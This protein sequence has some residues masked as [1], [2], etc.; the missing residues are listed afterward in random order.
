MA[1]CGTTDIRNLVR[2]NFTAHTRRQTIRFSTALM[3]PVILPIQAFID[4]GLELLLPDT[5][6]VQLC[7]KAD[8]RL[9][10]DSFV[11]RGFLL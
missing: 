9:N 7:L 8:I 4:S 3:L 2:A 6:N 5:T 1:F 11:R 10:C